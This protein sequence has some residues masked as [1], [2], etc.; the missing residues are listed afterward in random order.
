MWNL[1]FGYQ[2]WTWLKPY[3]VPNMCRLFLSTPSCRTPASPTWWWS[4]AASWRSP[5]T[6]ASSWRRT[7]PWSRRW[8]AATTR[9]RLPARLTNRKHAD[10]RLETL[11][12][13]NRQ[14]LCGCC[15]FFKARTRMCFVSLVNIS[16]VY[17]KPF[18]LPRT[19]E[20]CV[21]YCRWGELD[22]KGFNAAPH[23]WKDSSENKQNS[24]IPLY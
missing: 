8:T 21:F 10:T 4:P 15:C 12:W 13:P 3:H 9:R 16:L 14:R 19:D 17:N 5:T 18:F 2:D 24:I 11:I 6:P 1:V 23:S 7:A 20:T 22:V